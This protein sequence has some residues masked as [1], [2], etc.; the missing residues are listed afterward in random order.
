MGVLCGN[1]K[2][3]NIMLE[4]YLAAAN[5]GANTVFMKMAVN[6]NLCLVQSLKICHSEKIWIVSKDKEL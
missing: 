6:S 5:S 1:L 2:L 4:L 3:K